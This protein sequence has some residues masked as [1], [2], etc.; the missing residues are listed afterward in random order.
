MLTLLN[1]DEI[2]QKLRVLMYQQQQPLNRIAKDCGMDAKTIQLASN[3]EMTNRTVIRFSRWFQQKD[4]GVATP[5]IRE[6]YS[7]L[8]SGSR[9]DVVIGNIGR[10][11]KEL[12]SLNGFNGFSRARM[13]T[14]TLEELN[15]LY[16][17]TENKLKFMLMKKHKPM[18]EH[19]HMWLYDKWDYW[20][21]K[22]KVELT[23][24][25]TSKFATFQP[26]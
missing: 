15:M 1:R 14:M 17:Q 26:R 16:Y 13:E 18:I 3:G 9:K 10:L 22:E 8:A 24:Q 12:R 6:N 4:L 7:Q 5:V 2:R 25:D 23:L 21:W 20:Q 11:F 19:F